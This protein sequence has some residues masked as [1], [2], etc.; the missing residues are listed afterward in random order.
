LISIVPSEPWRIK[1]VLNDRQ[2]LSETLN[3][4]SG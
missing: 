3:P 4:S 1:A 2:Q